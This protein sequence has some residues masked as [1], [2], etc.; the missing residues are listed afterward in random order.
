VSACEISAE[1]ALAFLAPGFAE[2]LTAA[3]R[4][5]LPWMHDLSL[6]PRQRWPEFAWRSIGY[7][8]GRGW[9]KSHGVACNVNADV[10]SGRAESVAL[11]GPTLDRV[12]EVQIDFLIATSPPWFRAE[13]YNDTVRWPNGVVAEVFTPE[14]PERPRSG[15][16][17]LAW[18]CEIV[19]WAPSTRLQAIKNITT[20]TRLGP[21]ARYVY[22]TTSQGRNDAIEFLDAKHVEDPTRHLLVNGTTFDNPLLSET[23]LRDVCTTYTGQAL[24]EELLGLR[25]AAAEGALFSQTTIDR[26][27]VAKAP[28]AE[29]DLVAVDP[30]LSARTTADEVGIIRGRR[31]RGHCYVTHDLSG[32]HA[33]EDW[34]RIVVDQCVDGAAGVVIERNHAG[35]LARHAIISE[36][37]TRGLGVVLLEK[38]EPWPERRAGVIFVRDVHAT[39]SKGT[40]AVGPAAETSHGRVHMVGTHAQLERELTTFVPGERVKSPNRYDA[41]NYLVAEL[42]G[43]MSAEA[44]D[45]RA[46]VR[47]SAEAA[48]EVSRRAAR[49]NTPAEI[50]RLL[51]GRGG[52]RGFGL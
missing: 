8:A 3:E 40:R 43:L 9:G 23:Y 38:A 45:A 17:D 44:P 41:H 14:E 51:G 15:N 49:A 52:S 50:A 13:R 16:F 19:G 46:D 28:P 26:L 1:Q 4:F 20:A 6:R 29:L 33:P 2:S 35:D 27:R 22:D 37:R 11:M 21:R 42:A 18:L 25:F 47:A 36:A 10:E 7:T 24:L 12:A 48:A 5:V 32:H 39:Q 31:G 34:S 30:A